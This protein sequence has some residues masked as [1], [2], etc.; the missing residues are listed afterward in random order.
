MA[1]F[2]ELLSKSTPFYWDETLDRIFEQSKIQI[3]DSIE[4][5]VRSFSTYKTTCLATDW[6]KTGIGFVLSQKHCQ[7]PGKD[8]LCSPGHWQVIY[9]GSRFTTDAES[10]YAPI[11]G[12]ALALLYGL[13]SCRMFVMGCPE[14][15]IAVDHKP[16]IPIF[17]DRDLDKI[18]NPRL[19][20]I[21][22]K[23]LPYT[24]TVISIPGKKNVGPDAASRIP[25]LTTTLP[26][27]CIED[28]IVAAINDQQT[29]LAS[30]KLSTICNHARNDV[31]YRNLIVLIENGFP[32]RKELTPDDLHEFWSLRDELYT[33]RDTIFVAGKPLIPRSLRKDLLDELHLGHQGVSTMKANARQR[34]FWPHMNADINTIRLNCQ[35]CN[36]IPPSLPKGPLQLTDDPEY[37]FQ[38]AVADFFHM[39]GHNFIIYSDR[40]SGWTEIASA[41][42]SNA[43]ATCNTFRKYFETFG[44]PEEISTDGG[45]PFNSH[46]YTSFLKRWNVKVRM[47]SAY[48]PQSNGRAEASVKT[49]KRILTTNVT[50]SGSLDTDAVAK[51]LLLHRNTPPP[52]I[53]VSPAELLFGR[54]INDHLPNPITFRKEWSE[55]ADARETAYNK[56]RSH[57][58]NGD[59]YKNV[60]KLRPLNIGDNVTVQNQTGQH[61][62]RWDRTGIVAETLPNSQYRVVVDGSRRTTLRNRHFLRKISPNTRSTADE[63]PAVEAPQPENIEEVPTTITSESACEEQTPATQSSPKEKVTIEPPT[64]EQTVVIRRSTRE[65][66]IPPKLKDY[67]LY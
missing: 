10:R 22:E 20:K 34:F 45:P 19:L 36:Q 51:A 1:P 43:I 15:L 29:T 65:R 28:S 56:R 12:E 4:D 40:F 61:R 55:L 42:T 53:G 25:P 32:N 50:P 39:V 21:R 58:I 49:I 16:L 44:V 47:S 35:R 26:I 46:E 2:R 66:R 63:E 23:A 38:H 31:Q 67:I 6:C 27:A 41:A 11:E 52:D 54:N 9:A 64:Q 59:N 14:L 3:I 18:R 8:P 5:G 33:N 13:E 7:C 37:P 62:L 60:R 57:A 48:Y 30:I 17:N 24:F